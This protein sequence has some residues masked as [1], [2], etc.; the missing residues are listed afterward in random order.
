MVRVAVGAW[1]FVVGSRCS[2]SRAGTTDFR[3]VWLAA[4]VIV[5]V[6]FVFA[7]RSSVVGAVLVVFLFLAGV[8]VLVR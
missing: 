6:P 7:V 1:V 4:V 3:W 5:T 2:C 8:V